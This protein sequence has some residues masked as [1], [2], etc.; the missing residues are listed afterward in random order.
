LAAYCDEKREAEMMDRE[1]L[2]A[3]HQ[4]VV[5]T[6]G[7]WGSHNVA[8]PYGLFTI[9]PEPRGDNYR[10]AK[11]VQ[12]IADTLRRP[13]ADLRIL[14]LGCGEGLYAVEFAQQ[15]AEVVGVEARLPSLAKAQ[16]CQQVLGLERLTFVQDDVRAVTLDRYGPFDVVLCSGILYHLDQPD[17]FDFL[18]SMKEMCRGVCII[19]TRIS[20]S[21]EVEKTYAGRTYRG[22][23]YREHAPG[24]TADQKQADM[25]ASIDNDESFWFT[26]HDLSNF[27][28]DMGFTSVL[29]CLA[30]VPWMLRPDRTTLVATAGHRAHP[31]NEIGHALASRRWP[32]SWGA[33]GGGPT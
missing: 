7:P 10:T 5:E 33:E 18:K 19:D 32:A 31:Y 11:F 24:L 25:G 26:K 16:F 4:A 28:M 1:A 12:L 22:S 3:A 30:P 6:H 17:V 21:A 29:E 15:G 14:D 2:V 20:L 13:F 27:L 9:S 8:L 23:A